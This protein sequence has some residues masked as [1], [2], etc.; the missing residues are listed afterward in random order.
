MQSKTSARSEK[1]RR[2]FGCCRLGGGGDRQTGYSLGCSFMFCL[3]QCSSCREQQPFSCL[4][5][6]LLYR[7]EL[8]G[9]LTAQIFS[10]NEW[11]N[12]NWWEEGGGKWKNNKNHQVGHCM[13]YV[14]ANV[15]WPQTKGM[16]ACWLGEASRVGCCRSIPFRSHSQLH[17][18]RRKLK[19]QPFIYVMGA[20]ALTALKKHYKIRKFK[21][22]F[23]ITHGPKSNTRGP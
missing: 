20:T 18:K 8:R 3:T 23:K 11:S 19:Q 2:E 13:T 12:C 10:P 14:A 4:S 22:S 1:L 16:E 6:S 21:E 15:I 17:Q 5:P 7:T 9:L